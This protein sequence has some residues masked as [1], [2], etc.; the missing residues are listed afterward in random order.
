MCLR[1]GC[2]LDGLVGFGQTLEEFVSSCFS[3]G[4]DLYMH[5]IDGSE[6]SSSICLLFGKAVR[7]R[8]S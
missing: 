6:I 1:L 2:P 3:S 4:R 8:D 5:V 7:Y